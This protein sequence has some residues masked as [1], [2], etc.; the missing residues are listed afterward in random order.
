MSYGTEGIYAVPTLVS[1]T[2]IFLFILF[3]AFMEKAGVIDFFNDISMAAFRQR[4]GGP[5]QG[6]RCSPRR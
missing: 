4:S 6:R 3:G 1:A 5:G 2:Y